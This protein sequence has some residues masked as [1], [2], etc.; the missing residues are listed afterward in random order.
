[1]KSKLKD[2][3]RKGKIMAPPNI[4]AYSE[5]IY[6]LRDTPD[7][8]DSYTYYPNLALP[9][10]EPSIYGI[11]I[12]GFDHKLG[13]NIEFKFPEEVAALDL[14]AYLALPDCAHNEEADFTYFIVN[15]EQELYYGIA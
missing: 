6:R 9:E 1:M 11:Y 12:V 8:P 2:F 5:F 7:I 13:S 4:K 3:L 14:I 15:I 10:V